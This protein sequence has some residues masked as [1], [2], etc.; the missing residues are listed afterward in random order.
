MNMDKYFKIIAFVTLI[1]ANGTSLSAQ[2]IL[3]ITGSW[4]NLFYQDERNKYTNPQNAD[5]TNPDFW[6]AKVRELHE[7]G[8]EFLIFMATANE[9]KADYPS[10]IM[11]WAYDANRKS[12]VCAIMDEADRLGMKVFM[13][14][15]WA[16][17]QDDNLRKPAILQRQKDIMKELAKLYGN[18]S[19]FYGWYLPVEDCLGPILSDAAVDA[20]NSLVDNAHK[21]T[22]GKKTMISPYGFFCSEFDNPK[23]GQQIEKLKVDII[24]Y[25]DEVG[26]VREEF[27]M[28]RLK[29]NWKKM[30][31]IHDRTHIEMWANCELFTWEGELNSRQSALIPAAMPRVVSQLAAATRGG[32]ER[33]ISFMVYG[34][35]DTH[36]TPYIMAQPYVSKQTVDDYKAW[37]V[38][39]GRWAFLNASFMENV[40][41]GC[42][43]ENNALF[44]GKLGD[45]SPLS[46]NWITFSSGYNNVDVP[47][48]AGSINE[49]TIRFLCCRKRS[50]VL[51]KKVHLYT[52]SDGINY[53]RISSADVV[54]HPNNQHDTWIDCVSFKCSVNKRCRIV[55]EAEQKVAIDEVFI[56]PQIGR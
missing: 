14:I 16:K 28:V 35:W 45:E 54:N 55:F 41:N 6:Q 26:C 5:N 20:V 1:V 4:I 36:E 56:N 8:I 9:G 3:P 13:S 38:N 18:R 31:A 27:P 50:I 37:R 47:N 29:E 42:I 53:K 12:P 52:S 2:D 25:Q 51:P 49:I 46:D 39:S 48:V 17:N 22:P 34:I 33:I 11:P 30:R 7:L 44:D 19:S 10:R 32:A 15:G 21:L 40:T 23:F 43:V 24:A